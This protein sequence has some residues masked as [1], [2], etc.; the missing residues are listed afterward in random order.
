MS[1]N[2]DLQ[3]KHCRP[4]EGGTPPL[5]EAKV[6]TLLRQLDGWEREGSCIGKTFQFK[7]FHQTMAFVNAVAWIAHREGHHPDLSVGYNRCRVSYTT[8]AIGGLSENDFICAAKVN[9]LL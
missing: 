2:N 9:A 1:S 5:A 7:N 6:A 3:E 8:H 4:C